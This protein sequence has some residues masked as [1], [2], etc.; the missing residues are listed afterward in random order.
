MMSKAS[1]SDAG[2]KVAIVTGAASGLG[3]AYARRLAE[4]GYD[5]GVCDLEPCDATLG[6]VRESGRRAFGYRADV[7]RPDDVQRFAGSVEREL[8][9]A[10]VLVNNVGISPYAPFEQ[11]T[12]EEWR[13]VMSVNLDS[14]FLVTRAF[15]DGMKAQGWGRVVNVTSALAWDAQRRDVVAYVTSKMGILGFTR[16][17]AAEVGEHGITV[18]AICPGVVRTSLMEERV[19]PEQWDVYI[20]RQSIK[21]IA[22]PHDLLGA[23]SLLVSDEAGFI[24]AV[25]LPVH[26]GR[27]W[28]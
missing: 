12:I 16:A 15:L 2:P 5:V 25:N 17:L 19:A 21:D 13:Q 1:G 11:L 14:L 6:A 9:V 18:N 7:S 23:L 22:R 4:L 20:E 3:A 10:R 27:V 8:G 24:T 28:L 26:G